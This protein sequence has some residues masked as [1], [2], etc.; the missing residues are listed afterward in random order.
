MHHIFYIILYHLQQYRYTLCV[1]ILPAQLT[2]NK[3]YII[4]HTVDF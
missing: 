1:S 3:K 4:G 2:F